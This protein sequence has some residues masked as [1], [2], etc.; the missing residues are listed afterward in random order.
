MQ[1]KLLH[2]SIVEVKGDTVVVSVSFSPRGG[3]QRRRRFYTDDALDLARETRPNLV[4]G[5]LLSGATTANNY[6]NLEAEW[7]FEI[8]KK[9]AKKPV[10]PEVLADAKQEPVHKDK[11]VLKGVAEPPKKKTTKKKNTRK[12]LKSVKQESKEVVSD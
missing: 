3:K 7:V 8:V 9:D 11:G 10:A 1:E 2:T 4:I 5:K 6:S 12:T